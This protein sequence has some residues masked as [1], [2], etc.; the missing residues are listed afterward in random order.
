MS[1][2]FLPRQLAVATLL[3]LALSPAISSADDRCIDAM[4][5]VE[6]TMVR[7]AADRIDSAF[8][9]VAASTRALATPTGGWPR[10]RASR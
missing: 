1:M 2:I 6:D 5:V 3:L 4:A 10:H 9:D 7:L 8:D